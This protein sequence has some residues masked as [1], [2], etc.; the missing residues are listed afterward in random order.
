MGWKL[1]FNPGICDTLEGYDLKPYKGYGVEKAWYEDI[2]GRKIPNTD[3]YLVF[4][5]DDYIGGS[6]R[7]IADAHRFIDSIIEEA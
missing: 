6:Y 4:E 3:H 5:D 7:T 2:D 1:K